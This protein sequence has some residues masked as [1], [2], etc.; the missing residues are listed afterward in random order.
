[1]RQLNVTLRGV[2]LLYLADCVTVP[3]TYY[4]T[5]NAPVDDL[6]TRRA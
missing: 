4:A 6:R 1:V 5:S 3:V 2:A